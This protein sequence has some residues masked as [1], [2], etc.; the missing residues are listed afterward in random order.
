MEM[1][2]T[3]A[4]LCQEDLKNSNG[5]VPLHRSLLFTHPLSCSSSAKVR[6]HRTVRFT[7]ELLLDGLSKVGIKLAN[8]ELR[9]MIDL[10]VTDEDG[11]ISF[12]EYARL[13]ESPAW[14]HTQTA[15]STMEQITATWKMLDLSGDGSVETDELVDVLMPFCMDLSIVDKMIRIADANIDEKVSILSPAADKI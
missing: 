12:T 10:A 4:Y 8:F 2:E 3:F 11:L 14:L 15:A 6:T 7:K 5:F 13:Y 9:E 1:E